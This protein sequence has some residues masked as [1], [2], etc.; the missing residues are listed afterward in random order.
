MEARLDFAFPQTQSKE[1]KTVR[2]KMREMENRDDSPK[3]RIAG[4]TLKE[5]RNI[6]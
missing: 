5:A 2:E 1:I 6:D 3:L 4:K